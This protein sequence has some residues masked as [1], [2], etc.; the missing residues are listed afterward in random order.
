MLK[1]FREQNEAYCIFMYMSCE[2][3]VIVENEMKN[4]RDWNFNENQKDC[5]PE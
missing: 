2:V 4:I 1:H 5:V 3:Y